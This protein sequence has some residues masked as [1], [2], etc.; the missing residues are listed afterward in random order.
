MKRGLKAIVAGMALVP[1]YA[2]AAHGVVVWSDDFSDDTPGARP[3]RDFVGGAAGEDYQFTNDA[4]NAS[5]LV[6]GTVGNP[7][8]SMVQT[9]ITLTGGGPIVTLPMDHF[10]PFALDATNNLLRV[11]YDFRVDS[12]TSSSGSVNPRFILRFANANLQQ[13]VI[14][15]ARGG[16]VGGTLDDGDAPFDNALFAQVGGTGS[17]FPPTTANAIGLIPGTGWAPGF[18]F[19]DYDADS[20][21]AALNDTHDEFYR[22]ELTYDFTDGSLDGVVTNQTTLQGTTFSRTM[23]SGLAF[24]NSSARGLLFAGATGSTDVHYFDNV[25][26]EVVPEPASAVLVLAAAGAAALS[27]RRCR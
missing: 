26:V 10:A 9:D 4:A 14:G 2:T 17:A 3:S 23:Q 6:S 27:R 22:F 21:D 24:T 8:N 5:T 11:T 7:P 1:I 20:A 15:F 18:D 16:T 12:F 25:T 13:L 19:G